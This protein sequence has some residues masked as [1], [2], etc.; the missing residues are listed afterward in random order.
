[1]HTKGINSC[2]PFWIISRIESE[3]EVA[4]SCPTLCNPTDCS[5][6]GFSVHGILQARILEWVTISFFR[7]SSRS[8]DRTRV[9]HIGGSRFNL[10]ATRQALSTLHNVKFII[11][12]NSR[13]LDSYEL[14]S[15]VS[16]C[17]LPL[18]WQR[19]FSKKVGPSVSVIG[20]CLL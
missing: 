1:M 18:S 20:L 19:H 12:L 16:H 13:T 14:Q 5:L 9:S 3:S 10:W 15:T 11:T 2:M 6:P 8:R 4:Q 7:G 17:E